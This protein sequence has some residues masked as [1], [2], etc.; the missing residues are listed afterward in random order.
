MKF[1]T[2]DQ[3]WAVREAARDAFKKSGIENSEDFDAITA[4]EPMIIDMP[5]AEPYKNEA[6]EEKQKYRRLLV[7]A[8]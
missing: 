7:E 4:Y 2:R 6:L 3:W 1:E 8:V 5:P